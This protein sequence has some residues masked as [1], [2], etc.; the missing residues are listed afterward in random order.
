MIKFDMNLS[1]QNETIECSVEN[2]LKFNKY[3]EEVVIILPEGYKD[4]D[5]MP[6]Q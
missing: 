5:D 1:Y 2:S 6:L 4:F 3:G